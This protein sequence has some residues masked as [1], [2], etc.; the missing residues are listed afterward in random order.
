MLYMGTYR[1]L[2]SKRGIRLIV[3]CF[4]ITGIMRANGQG[5]PNYIYQSIY[6]KYIMFK[7]Q[8][9]VQKLTL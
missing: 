9:D 5:G 7:F 2:R 6:P 3:N 4:D 8:I 1:Q